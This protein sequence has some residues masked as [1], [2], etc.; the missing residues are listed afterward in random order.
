MAI[1]LTNDTTIDESN[2]AAALAM[3]HVHCNHVFLHVCN[4]VFM[5]KFRGLLGNNALF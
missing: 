1:Q 2:K 3:R 4:R 5:T